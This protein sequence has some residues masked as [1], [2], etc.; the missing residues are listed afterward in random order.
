MRG[1]SLD[2]ALLTASSGL[3]LTSRQLGTAAQNVAGAGVAG[4]TRKQVEGQSLLTGGVR[5]LDPRRDIDPALRLEARRAAAEEAAA[6]LRSDTL[7]ALSRL[8]GDPADGTSPAG[9]IGALRDSFASLAASPADS[10]AQSATLESARVLAGRMNALGGAL[11]RAR[12]GVQ[13]GLRADVGS[14]NTLLQDI[15]RLDILVRNETAAGRGAAALQDQRDAAVASLSTLVGVTPL[16]AENGGVTLML[17]GGHTLPLDPKASPFALADATVTAGSYHGAPAGTLPGL[18]LNG[19]NLADGA[20]LGGR[21]GEGFTLRDETLPRMQAELDMTAATLAHR[22]E[23]QG[24]RLFTEPGGGA[25]PDPTAAGAGPAIAGFAGR[26]A[27]NPAIAANPALLRD[28]TPDSGGFPPNLAGGPSG[29]T[30]LLNRVGDYAFGL[31]SAAGMP[32]AAIAGNNLGPGGTLATGT[33]GAQ[34]IGDYAAA[35]L[36]R[37]SAE[38]DAAS[39]AAAQSGAVRAQFDA[40]V[41]A[42]EG[43]DVD[44]EM[45]A[46]VQLQNAYAANARVMSVVQS[47]WDALLATVR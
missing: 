1:M 8:L 31:E 41:Q 16:A 26:M 40:M 22:L 47:M 29:Y 11:D 13:D 25:P 35:T 4:Y 23:E 7:G 17:P 39:A 42:R 2:S 36:G 45:A 12:Q 3:R 30:A 43:V 20:A 33:G 34:R 37:Q 46:M 15:A 24:L 32:H 14:A 38:A 21:I 10:T 28:G 5:A 27:V 6:G 44:A 19:M 9:L 18:T